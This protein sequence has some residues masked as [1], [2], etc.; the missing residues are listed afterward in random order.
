MRSY[1]TPVIGMPS[2]LPHQRLV[3]NLSKNGEL[4][5]VVLLWWSMGS[6][7]TL[8]G[9]LCTAGLASN[10]RVLVLCDKSLIGQWEGVVK[11]FNESEYCV[12]TKNIDVRHY[13][14]LTTEHLQPVRYDMCIVDEAHRFRNAFKTGVVGRGP[15][16]LPTWINAIMRCQ[17]IV[18][19]TGTPLVSDAHVEMHAL[20]KMMRTSIQA[21]LDG[22]IFFYSPQE[23]MKK[24]QHF[25]KTRME[26]VKCPM[27]Y[28]QVL[29]YF[30]NKQNNFTITVGKETYSVHRPV[31]NT[32]NSAL[33]SMSNNPFP[34]TPSE[35]PK[36]L[37]MVRRLKL[38]YDAHTKQLVYSQRLDTGIKALRDFWLQRFPT[39]QKQIFFI[40]GSQSASDR[41]TAI[42]RFNRGGKE[43]VARILFISDAAAQGVDLKE[44][45]SVHLLEP[46]D[47]LQEERQVINRAVRFKSHKSKEAQVHVYLYCTTFEPKRAPVGPLQATADELRMFDQTPASF[48]TK[49]RAA[50]DKMTAEKSTIDEQTLHNREDIDRKVQAAL[51]RLKRF[52][53]KGTRSPTTLPGAA[54]APSIKSH[55]R[56]AAVMLGTSAQQPDAPKR[57]KKPIVTHSR[58]T[59][60]DEKHRKTAPIKK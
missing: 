48:L 28:A 18:Y 7:K 42:T 54:C 57:A 45:D 56:S 15:T 40:D 60:A 26:L 6:G 8:G 4:S 38:G 2:L 10:A 22:R 14:T 11:R 35:S 5:D 50:L 29:K 27:S 21:P 24:Q 59:Y 49:L 36:L 17:R 25:A 30:A 46:G 55:K 34:D 20:E 23:D 1:G 39:T 41:H 58:H 47:R 16:E 44:V 51:E 37:E 19:L 12:G 3:F 52:V 13:Q 31:R 43:A 32:Y 9:L 33:V 53:Y